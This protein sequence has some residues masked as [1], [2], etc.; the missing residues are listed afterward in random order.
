MRGCDGP[1]GRLTEKAI[2]ERRD[3]GS[4]E[5]PVGSREGVGIV[6]ENLCE[7]A[8][9][10]RGVEPEGKKVPVFQADLPATVCGASSI[11]FTLE[12]ELDR[13]LQQAW[14][15]RLQDLAKRGRFQVVLRQAEIRVVEHVEALRPELHTPVLPDFEVLEQ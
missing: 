2:I 15:T 4:D 5:L 14:R 1:V 6:K 9:G 3:V 8:Q 10:T 12:N 13:Q 7:L 11:S